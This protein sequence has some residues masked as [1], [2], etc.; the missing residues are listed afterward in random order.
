MVCGT[1]LHIPGKFRTPPDR[2]ETANAEDYASCLRAS[3]ENLRRTPMRPHNSAKVFLSPELS[4]GMHAFIRTDAVRKPFKVLQWAV[5][6]FTLLIND[7]EDSLNRIKLAHLGHTCTK[8]ADSVRCMRFKQNFV[9]K[10][11]VS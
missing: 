3:F 1:S 9:N 7:R 5:K 11:L 2:T 10:S 4:H 6:Y 8:S